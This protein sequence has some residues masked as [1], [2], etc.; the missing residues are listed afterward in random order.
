MTYYTSD[1][2]WRI[3]HK[4]AGDIEIK[5]G[6]M[7]VATVHHDPGMFRVESETNA[8]L[9]EAAPELIDACVDMLKHVPQSERRKEIVELVKRIDPWRLRRIGE[10]K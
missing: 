1:I 9:I 10:I 7:A 2:N 3:S 6:A 4:S 8:K 5:A